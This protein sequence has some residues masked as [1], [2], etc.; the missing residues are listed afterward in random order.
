MRKEIYLAVIDRLKTIKEENG[1]E[2]IKHFD[3]WNRNTDFID[4]E[5]PWPRPAIFIEFHPIKWSNMAGGIQTADISFSL[6][7]VTDWKGGSE[8]GSIHQTETL[9][10]FSL[11]DRINKALSGYSKLYAD[12]S[13]FRA[14]QRTGSNTNH[15]HEEILE[16]IET[17]NASVTDQSG[18]RI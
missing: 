9:Q 5:T 18:R 7:V 15:N 8:D 16:H 1:E 12:N 6:H 13:G 14:I 10:I 2:T 4:Q 3:L 17:F 11:L